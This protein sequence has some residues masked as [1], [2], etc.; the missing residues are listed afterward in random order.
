MV[1]LWHIIRE[2]LRAWPKA[3]MELEMF[4]RGENKEAGITMMQGACA[5]GYNCMEQLF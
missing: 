3:I 2:V 5:R 1:R 4:D